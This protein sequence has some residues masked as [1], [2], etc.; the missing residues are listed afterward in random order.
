M[1]DCAVGM[2][3]L[4]PER[5]EL[6]A[7]LFFAEE[8]AGNDQFLN[9]AGTF[10]NGA[11][12]DVA[13]KFFGGIVLDEAVAAVN[14][15]AFVGD[16]D[17]DFTGKKLGHAGFAREASIVLISKPRG[18]INEQSRR[19]HLRGHI[20]Q[21]ELNSLEFADGLAELLAL[22]GVANRGI[23]RPL[24]HAQAESGDG[25]ASSIQNLQAAGK[26][27]AF[28]AEKIFRRNF[29]VRE[30]NLG[31]VAGAHTEFVFFFAGPETRHSLFKN[32]RTDAVRAFGLVG[33][34]HG[35]ARV[36]IVAVGGE[37]FRAVENPIVAVAHSG[38]ARAAGV[39][40]GFGFGK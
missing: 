27:F 26:A 30:D 14:L 2:K 21:L 16:A 24:R 5:P 15:H 39:G 25:D 31:S 7:F 32:K 11:E 6:Q 29:A 4:R 20:R 23:E 34:G 22:L 28:R 40:A 13:V 36:R 12:L 19:F 35:D 1:H 17:G 10:A 18:L 9:F 37:G 38:A 8:L 33:D 3:T